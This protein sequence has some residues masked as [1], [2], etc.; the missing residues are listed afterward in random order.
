MEGGEFETEGEKS[1]KMSTDFSPPFAF[2]FLK[3]LKLV[4]GLPKWKILLKKDIFHA[5]KNWE[6]VRLRPSEKYS[7]Y[8]T[9]L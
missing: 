5:R 8:A 1:L 4:W 7:S 9:G 6:K 2:H 3:L